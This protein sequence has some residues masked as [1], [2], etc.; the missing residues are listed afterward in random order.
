MA[1]VVN[2]FP[3]DKGGIQ[4]LGFSSIVDGKTYVG[5]I[6]PGVPIS[7]AVLN[8]ERHIGTSDELL[9]IV[10]NALEDN[11]KVRVYETESRVARNAPVATTTTEMLTV[12]ISSIIAR[13]E[14]FVFN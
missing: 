2:K 7:C 12:L 9:D 4:A 5:L 6:E 3:F 8:E 10:I 13:I 11:K 1:Y 14:R